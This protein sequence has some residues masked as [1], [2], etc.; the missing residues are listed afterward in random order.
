MSVYC[1]CTYTICSQLVVSKCLHVLE[2]L[3]AKHGCYIFSEYSL[4]ITFNFILHD[5]Q[6]EQLYTEKCEQAYHSRLQTTH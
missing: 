6:T 2:Y 4:H 5:K 1:V 3:D